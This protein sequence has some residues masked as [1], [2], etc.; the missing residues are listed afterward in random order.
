[1]G[2]QKRRWK[3]CLCARSKTRPALTSDRPVGRVGCD[4]SK[5]PPKRGYSPPPRTQHVESR[6]EGDKWQRD[7]A[8]VGKARPV[9]RA[10]VFPCILHCE[11]S[12]LLCKFY[13]FNLVYGPF[14]NVLSW[15]K[16][17]EQNVGPGWGVTGG[18]RKRLWREKGG[19]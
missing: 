13:Y 17:G 4:F 11:T 1:M 14:E 5:P 10:P 8:A 16:K 6:A 12:T 18:K 7:L 19:S 9:K 3:E 2:R 15:L